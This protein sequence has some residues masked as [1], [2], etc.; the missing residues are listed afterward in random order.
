MRDGASGRARVLEEDG[1]VRVPIVFDNLIHKGEMPVTIGIFV[2]RAIAAMRFLR[3]AG[4]RII[5]VTNTIPWVTSTRDF[6][7]RNCCRR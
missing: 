3:T 6:F 5:A 7:W 1:D 4:E 2:I